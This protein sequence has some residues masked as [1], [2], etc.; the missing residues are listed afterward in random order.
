M[1]GIEITLRFNRKTGKKDIVISYESDADSLPIE[2]EEEHQ[3][4]V[5]KLLDEG[6]L[7][8]SELGEIQVE[9]ITAPPSGESRPTQHEEGEQ[10]EAPP[11]GSG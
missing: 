6:V 9:R 8:K 3:A 11:Q 4:I 2:H 5:A 7:Q 1:A 10:R